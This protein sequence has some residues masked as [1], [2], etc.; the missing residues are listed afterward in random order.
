MSAPTLEEMRAAY[1]KV[2]RQK[3]S[4]LARSQTEEGKERNRQ[5]ARAFYERHKTEVS[6]KRKIYYETN[7][8]KIRERQTKYYHTVLKPQKVKAEKNTPD[9]VECLNKTPKNSA[10]SSEPSAKKV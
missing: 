6:E 8:D 10:P 4:R 3:E 1:E 7:R 9:V 2:Q 5:K